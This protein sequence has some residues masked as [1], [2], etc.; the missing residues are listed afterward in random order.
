LEEA[1]LTQREKILFKEKIANRLES[2]ALTLFS[3][4]EEV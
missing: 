1:V 4:A 3:Q 2:I